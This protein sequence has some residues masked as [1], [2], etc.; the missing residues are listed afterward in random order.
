MALSN[1]SLGQI[2]TLNPPAQQVGG[3]VDTALGSIDFGGGAE[4]NTPGF[5]DTIDKLITNRTPE[6]LRILRQ[7]SG[8]ALRLSEQ[9]A[10]AGSDPLRQ[11]AGLEAFDEQNAILGL[12]GREAQDL[13]IGNIPVSEF[14]RELN[15]RQ[16][17]TQ[18]RQSFASGDVSGAS[19]QA[20]QQ[21]A[22]GQQSDIIQK[23]LGQLEPLVAG[24]RG[25]RTTLSA[26][27][28]ANR[29]RQAQ[30][31]SGRGIQ[32]SNIRI[33]AS[34]PIIQSTLQRAELSGLQ[35][36][37]AANQKAS[38]QNQLAS[39]AGQFAPQI[40]SLFSSPTQ[41]TATTQTGFDTNFFPEA[42]NIGVA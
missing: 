31:L 22:G 30:I 28:E 33:G 29:A 6:A 15:R 34:A 9:A 41:S 26:Q 37:A 38:Q 19:L 13:A 39:L 8:E 36:I 17:E 42:G 18:N 24:A 7:G 14:D 2:N 1:I 40:G 5:S 21:L 25:V 27:A 35:G 11:F 23:R 32:E 10:A 4:T 12:S 3:V 20:A 16:T